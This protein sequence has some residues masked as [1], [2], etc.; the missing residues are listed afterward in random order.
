MKM[1]QISNRVNYLSKHYELFGE[2]DFFKNV[3][4]KEINSYFT[5]GAS[6]LSYHFSVDT[7]FD[8]G[9]KYLLQK[10]AYLNADNTKFKYGIKGGIKFYP[11]NKKRSIKF[12]YLL[13]KYDGFKINSFGV[14]IMYKF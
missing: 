10:S 8:F 12:I 11:L 9:D 2:A 5:V 7:Q 6:Y 14:N 13:D 4:N 3:K 1:M